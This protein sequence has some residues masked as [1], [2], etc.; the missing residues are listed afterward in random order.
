MFSK[1]VNTQIPSA[2]IDYVQLNKM[3][4]YNIDILKSEITDHIDCEIE[5]FKNEI[6]HIKSD[7]SK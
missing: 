5:R 2:T 1:K 6:N 4:K 3:M 7:L